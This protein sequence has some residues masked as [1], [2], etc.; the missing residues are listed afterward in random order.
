MGG[1]LEICCLFPDF[2]VLKFLGVGLVGDNKIGC[3]CGRHKCMTSY[4]NASLYSAATKACKMFA[5]I[6]NS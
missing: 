1:G 2:I 3:F 6:K 5:S 4:S